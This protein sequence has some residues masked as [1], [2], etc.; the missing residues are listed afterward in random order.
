MTE[1]LVAQRTTLI[2]GA[3]GGL[4]FSSHLSRKGVEVK[5]LRQSS[6]FFLWLCPCCWRW[7]GKSHSHATLCCWLSISLLRKLPSDAGSCCLPVLRLDAGVLWIWYDSPVTLKYNNYLVRFFWFKGAE[8]TWERNCSP[9][10][11]YFYNMS[12]RVYVVCPGL[13]YKDL[14][15]AKPAGVVMKG[16]IE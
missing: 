14:E 6:A 1:W 2:S 15:G 7:E 8:V 5:A 13:W 11:W 10:V 9:S 4:C 12:L 16:C 3:A